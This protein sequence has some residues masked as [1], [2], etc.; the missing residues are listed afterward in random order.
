MSPT[1]EALPLQLLLVRPRSAPAICSCF[2][3]LFCFC[4]Y[5]S[6]YDPNIFCLRFV[7]FLPLARA[8]VGRDPEKNFFHAASTPS[9]SCVLEFSFRISDANPRARAGR[10]K[11]RDFQG[12]GRTLRPKNIDSRGARHMLL[13]F[14]FPILTYGSSYDPIFFRVC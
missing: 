13:L 5:V 4:T 9:D 6:S 8:G 1:G 3:W 12:L 14:I 11:K 10:C 7:L 2:W